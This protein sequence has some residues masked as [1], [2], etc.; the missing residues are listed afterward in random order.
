TFL[1][2]WQLSHRQSV[3]NWPAL[4]QH[5]AT[6][7]AL[8]QLRHRR[9]QA[10]HLVSSIDLIDIASLNGSPLTEAQSAELAAQLRDALTNL[11]EQLSEC[12]CLRHLND[13]SYEQIAEELQ[14]SV[15]AVGVNLHRATQRL[16]SALAPVVTPT[17]E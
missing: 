6:A 10:K 12:Y 13:F 1:S 3:K 9:R 7:R 2:A 17:D 14:I 16:R 8:D 5:L 4:L 15:S 11:P